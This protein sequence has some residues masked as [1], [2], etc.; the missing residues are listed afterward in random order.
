MSQMDAAST[1][2]NKAIQNAVACL[3]WL[4]CMNGAGDDC[5]HGW[6]NRHRADHA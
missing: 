2:L 1:D 4:K 6:F 3:L 5:G